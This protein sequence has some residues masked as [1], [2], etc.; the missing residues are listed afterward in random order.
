MMQD[1]VKVRI[2]SLLG[3]LAALFVGM[4]PRVVYF[5]LI[6]LCLLVPTERFSSKRLAWAYRTLIIGSAFAA[7][8]VWLVPRLMAG[9]GSGD[10]RGGGTVDPT[11]QVAY[12]LSHPLEYAQTLLRFVMPP[13]SMEGGVPDTE[14]HNLIGGFLSVEASPGLLANYGYL[15]RTPWPF[16]AV[17][18]VVL[19]W[20]TLTDK[21][22]THRLGI[23]PGIVSLVLCLGVFLMIVTALYFDFTPVGL[24]EIHGVQRRY[25]LPMMFP[26]LM[27]VGPTFLG[28]TGESRRTNATWYNGSVLGCMTAILLGSFWCSCISLIV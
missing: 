22:H 10:S 27:F 26:L 21:D 14:G 23:L 13:L 3:M 17:L 18:W 2:P 5:P 9:L 6:F 25:L 15:P 4:L 12:I 20:T 16:T 11:A 28:L 24:D 8:G 7:L 19:L 1:N